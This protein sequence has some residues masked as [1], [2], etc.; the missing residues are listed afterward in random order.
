MNCPRVIAEQTSVAEIFV[1]EINCVAQI[2][3][4]T[5]KDC[6]RSMPMACS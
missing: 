1:I 4:M 5:A 6:V 2:E 3:L